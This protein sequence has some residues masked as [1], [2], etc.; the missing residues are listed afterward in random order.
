MLALVWIR[1]ELEY[2]DVCKR[3]GGL[4]WAFNAWEAGV[5]KPDTGGFWGSAYEISGRE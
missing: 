1:N 5:L 2:V 3:V 4:L